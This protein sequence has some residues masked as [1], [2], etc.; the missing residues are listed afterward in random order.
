LLP[1]LV[2]ILLQMRQPGI[3]GATFFH[4]LQLLHLGNW[5][6]AEQSILSVEYNLLLFGS[7]CARAKSRSGTQKTLSAAPRRRCDFLRAQRR[8]E[9]QME[10]IAH[11]CW[12][13]GRH[14]RFAQTLG[15]R[16]NSASKK[17]F[18][19]LLLPAPFK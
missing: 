10:K 2:Q 9:K 17:V 8:Q 11:D 7:A 13:A 5:C 14:E 1:L 15:L 4:R 6:H 18:L 19:L 12:L 16:R 3:W